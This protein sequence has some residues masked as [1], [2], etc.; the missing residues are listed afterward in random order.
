MS[1]AYGRCRRDAAPGSNMQPR[2]QI[3]NLLEFL[4]KRRAFVVKPSRACS[5][6]FW[7]CASSAAFAAEA[8]RP[9]RAPRRM[10]QRAAEAATGF[11]V[12]IGRGRRIISPQAF[13]DAARAAY[14]RA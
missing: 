9:D 1:G 13:P 11:P 6:G 2:F 5:A 8:R 10:R 3:G 7:D 4:V 12:P 14:H